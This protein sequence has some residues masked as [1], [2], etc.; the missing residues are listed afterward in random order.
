MPLQRTLRRGTPSPCLI[1]VEGWGDGRGGGVC[2]QG[3][4][5]ETERKGK[6]RKGEERKCLAREGKEVFSKVSKDSCSHE[7]MHTR[8]SVCVCD[9][10]A[11]FVCFP[12]PHPAPAHLNGENSGRVSARVLC[13]V[14]VEVITERLRIQGCR[15]H[16]NLPGRRTAYKFAREVQWGEGGRWVKSVDG[17]G[18]GW[19]KSVDGIGG[20][21][22]KSVDGIGG[23][24][25]KSVDGIGGAWVKSVDGIGGAWVNMCLK[26]LSM[27]WRGAGC[28]AAGENANAME[29]HHTL[30]SGLFRCTLFRSPMQ[31]SMNMVLLQRDGPPSRAVLGFRD[32]R[33]RGRERERDANTHTHTH[34]HTLTHTRRAAARFVRAC[35]RVLYPPFV[36]L[37]ENNH[38][39]PPK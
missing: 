25:T 5:W 39:I 6:E 17:I 11:D 30:R 32:K 7:C 36:R 10:D 4:E 22:A 20:G 1:K 35:V 23:G 34:T 19:V 24:W 13:V 18:G 29:L 2:G 16:N 14:A 3:G 33:S 26:S 9:C 12:F 31:M 15:R 27:L 38:R 21:W 28:G 8:V 37:V